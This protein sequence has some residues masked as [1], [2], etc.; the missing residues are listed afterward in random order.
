MLNCFI[1]EAYFIFIIFSYFLSR[2]K[3]GEEPSGELT[4]GADPRDRNL[5]TQLHGRPL[6]MDKLFSIDF[7]T[8]W[9]DRQNIY[10]RLS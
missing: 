1:H 2:S 10:T 4:E 7:N 6:Q 9:M 3:K 8:L 5:L